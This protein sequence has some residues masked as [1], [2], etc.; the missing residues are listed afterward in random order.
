MLYTKELKRVYCME[1]KRNLECL[2]K[3][4][5]LMGETADEDGIEITF[6]ALEN[7]TTMLYNAQKAVAELNCL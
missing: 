2:G 4:A 7:I 5:E 3:Y 1:L 6:N